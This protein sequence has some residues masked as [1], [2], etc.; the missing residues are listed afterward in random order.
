MK[1][2]INLKNEEVKVIDRK[3]IPD[4]L[5]IEIVKIIKAREKKYY[6]KEDIVEF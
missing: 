6:K 3:K 2:I 1:T 5:I 4:E